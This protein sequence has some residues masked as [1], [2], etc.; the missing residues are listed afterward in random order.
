[1]AGAGVK[2]HTGNK[3]ISYARDRPENRNTIKG[4]GPPLRGGISVR[5]AMLTP[6]SSVKRYQ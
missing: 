5:P 1:M 4:R 3:C 6:G 2:R